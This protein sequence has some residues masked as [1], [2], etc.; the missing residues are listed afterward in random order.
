M[1]K[2]RKLLLFSLLLLSTIISSTCIIPFLN[3]NLS[4]YNSIETKINDP[5]RSTVFESYKTNEFIFNSSSGTGEINLL[6]FSKW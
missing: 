6:S 3:Q 1:K 4:S 2:H 5:K